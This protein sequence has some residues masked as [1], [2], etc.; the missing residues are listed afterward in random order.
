MYI[1]I[2][3]NFAYE[4]TYTEKIKHMKMVEHAVL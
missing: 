1:Y 4:F 2:Y 3:Q